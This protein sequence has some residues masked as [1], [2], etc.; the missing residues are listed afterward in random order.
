VPDL[1]A[2][3]VFAPEPRLLGEPPPAA[4]AE[5]PNDNP[6]LHRGARWLCL[7]VCSPARAVWRWS[8]QGALAPPAAVA[9]LA[10]PASSAP[11]PSAARAAPSEPALPWVMDID[12]ARVVLRHRVEDVPPPPE[13]VY[14]PFRRSLAAPP[15]PTYGAV[16]VRRVI[17]IG[18]VPR[19]VRRNRRVDIAPCIAIGAAPPAPVLEN[20][21]QPAEAVFSAVEPAALQPP[22]AAL[23]PPPAAV[24]PPP[25]RRAS[26]R[27]RLRSVLHADEL[28]Q[29]ILELESAFGERVAVAAAP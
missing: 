3:S 22:P 15:P 7:Q 29:A 4:A 5:F 9:A 24:T 2:F 26:R 6:R 21:S 1:N 10:A 19:E 27:G 17:G 23:A 25:P 12:P 16:Q 28:R 11:V 14:K 8:Q 20:V 13:F 18:P